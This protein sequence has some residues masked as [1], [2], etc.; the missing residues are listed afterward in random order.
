M[1]LLAVFLKTMAELNLFDLHPLEQKGFD[2]C[3]RFNGLEKI[4][5]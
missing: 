3:E 2:G 5:Y 4:F 1:N